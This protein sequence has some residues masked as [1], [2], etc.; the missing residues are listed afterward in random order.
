MI[1]VKTK[2]KEDLYIFR[3][4]KGYNFYLDEEFV[5]GDVVIKASNKEEAEKKCLEFI[6]VEEMR[7]EKWELDGKS[8]YDEESLLE[9]VEEKTGMFGWV[10]RKR[11]KGWVLEIE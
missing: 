4:V 11:D 10:L 6:R 1:L 2:V 9:Y 7:P 5:I 3:E 8:F